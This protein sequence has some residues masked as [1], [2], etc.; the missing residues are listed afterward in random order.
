MLAGEEIFS[1]AQPAQLPLV[2]RSDALMCLTLEPFSA[3]SGCVVTISVEDDAEALQP[4][5]PLPPEQQQRWEVLAP[6]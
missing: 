2:R 4:A 6:W 1:V 5:F 3:R